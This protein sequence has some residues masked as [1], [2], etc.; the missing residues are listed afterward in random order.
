MKVLFVVTAFYPEQAIGSIRVTKFAKY[1]HKQGASITVVSLTPPPWA[2]RDETL[3]FQGLKGIRWDT[4]DQSKFFKNF[5]QRARVATIGTGSAVEGQGAHHVGWTLKPF[6]RQNAHL[7]YT[8]VKAFDWTLRVRKH[9]R[10][11]FSNGG[12]DIIY[13]SYP[14]LA[15]PFSGIMLKRMGFGKRLVIDF[16]DPVAPTGTGFLNVRRWIQKRMTKAADLRLYVSDG[17]RNTVVGAVHEAQNRTINNG[18]DPDDVLG[19]EP[20]PTSDEAPHVLSFVYTGAM[21]GGKRDLAP[22]FSAI[23]E[24]IRKSGYSSENTVFKY[25]GREGDLFRKYAET[26]GLDDRVIDYGRLTRTESLAL[27]QTADICLL[28]TWN[29]NSEQGVLTGKVFE[30]FMLRK[31]IVAI[32]GGDRSGSEIARVIKKLNAGH[33]F[34]DAEPD[35]ISS[36][37]KWLKEALDRKLSTGKMP[38]KY[39]ESVNDFNI[40][41]LTANLHKE[42]VSLLEMRSC[43]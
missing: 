2:A 11:N 3:W 20:L 28:A 10:E 5:F 1:L 13:C 6:I 37:E 22:F 12:F 26:C 40:E 34:E 18:Y 42:L 8:L 25:A 9:V 17:V 33:C 35:E 7:V 43:P 21:Y 30:Y 39:T 29:S 16:R 38:S 15:S 23:S 19:V 27:Q 31:P 24:V 41:K 14:S 32:V 36:L 4:I